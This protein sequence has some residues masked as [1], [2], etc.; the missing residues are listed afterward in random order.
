MPSP[1]SK[2]RTRPAA[3]DR[4]LLP[5]LAVAL[6][7]L[8]LVPSATAQGSTGSDASLDVTLREDEAGLTVNL[9]AGDERLSGTVV[10]THED[11]LL[12]PVVD[13]VATVNASA[14]TQAT[15]AVRNAPSLNFSAIAAADAS[16]PADV[17]TNFTVRVVDGNASLPQLPGDGEIVDAD[18]L[19]ELPTIATRTVEPFVPPEA[20]A[21]DRPV[22][23]YRVPVDWV[24]ETVE[25]DGETSTIY[26]GDYKSQ[27][28]ATANGTVV[29]GY[30]HQYR[31]N[32]YAHVSRDGGHTWTEPILVL[33]DVPIPD[34]NT[35]RP[36]WGWTFAE[37]AD[38]TVDFVAFNASETHGGVFKA[39]SSPTWRFAEM[40]PSTGEVSDRRSVEADAPGVDDAGGPP[41]FKP[42]PG[43]GWLVAALT[44]NADET[45]DWDPDN[46]TFWT[47]DPSGDLT[48]LRSVP[49]DHSGGGMLRFGVA[50][51][52]SGT[53]VAVVWIRLYEA[54]YALSTDGGQT[55]SDAEVFWEVEDKGADT[56][57]GPYSMHVDEDGTIHLTF[58]VTTS[59][60][61]D[62]NYARIPP[63]G[64]A[65]VT[66][67]NRETAEG[68]GEIPI[69][70]F[71]GD[72]VHV[73][74]TSLRNTGDYSATEF[75]GYFV[76]SVN[77]GRTFSSPYR[78]QARNPDLGLT[79]GVWTR[80][81]EKLVTVLP[82]GRPLV[83]GKATET[84][85]GVFGD[86][87]FALPFFD[88]QPDAR[89]ATGG[90]PVDVTTGDRNLTA[91]SATPSDV[92]AGPGSVNT[93][94]VALENTGNAT[95]T[96][97]GARLVGDGSYSMEI[98]QAPDDLRVEPGEQVEVPVV[99]RD[100]RAYENDLSVPDRLDIEV[101][102]QTLEPAPTDGNQT[103]RNATQRNDSNVDG[104]ATD[105]DLDEDVFDEAD[106][107]GD[108]RSR[109][110]PTVPAPGAALTLL[111]FSL[112]GLAGKLRRRRRW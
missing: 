102:A 70:S 91:T 39:W 73:F 10:V 69:A 46:T 23:T 19:D 112:A 53:N 3:I 101:D 106:G 5:I 25:E 83:L 96:V 38:G 34:H 58:D 64:P 6:L 37:R 109:S 42:L 36:L 13:R 97:D 77:G 48:R 104:N 61:F 72:R 84:I 105:D 110:R 22:E 78:I 12:G 85:D 80:G 81:A 54:Q 16:G 24:E 76:E 59:D 89:A 14:G 108:D 75:G 98:Q 31:E 55:F 18:E 65:Q 71:V 28:L 11:P 41:K 32:L 20:D 60:L 99:V 79:P 27:V 67:L 30:I 4:R 74:W 57:Q 44:D 93:V 100:P 92:M 51:S 107:T 50:A 21:V 40:D 49:F 47:L 33:E 95:A 2:D 88:P 94:T 87:L 45:S 17:E 35:E 90:V 29:V 43:G 9:S 111:A 7:A 52:P 63:T 66:S 8:L 82:D 1:G 103:D 56:L 15:V 62:A 86:H 26:H 68:G